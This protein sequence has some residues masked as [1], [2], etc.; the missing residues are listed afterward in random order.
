MHIRIKNSASVIIPVA[1]TPLHGDIVA[2]KENI[3]GVFWFKQMKRILNS[4]VTFG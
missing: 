4:S 2:N 1:E 3:F